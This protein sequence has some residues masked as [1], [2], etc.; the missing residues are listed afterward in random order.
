VLRQPATTRTGRFYDAVESR[1]LPGCVQRPRVPFALAANGPRTMAV[2]AR[3]A[4][5]WVTNGR[6]WRDHDGDVDA[7]VALVAA[8]SAALTDACSAIGREPSSIRRLLLVGGTQEPWFASDAAAGELAERYRSEAGITDLVLHWPVAGYGP[9]DV[10]LARFEA[11]AAA[12]RAT[13]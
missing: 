1:S 10:P 9:Y 5:T 13:T 7:C 4:E 3:S 2:T 8:Q 12:L 11:V 6:A